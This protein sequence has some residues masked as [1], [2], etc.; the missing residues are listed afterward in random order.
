MSPYRKK[1][2]KKLSLV[3]KL[4]ELEITQGH[5]H[6]QKRLRKIERKK[7]KRQ[8]KINSIVDKII[9]KCIK[10]ASK[11]YNTVTVD[12]SDKYVNDVVDSLRKKDDQWHITKLSNHMTISYP[13]IQISWSSGNK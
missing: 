11:G 12:V 6:Y 7:E 2:E 8:K 9:A 10:E 1:A 4:R 3:E 13:E 5:K